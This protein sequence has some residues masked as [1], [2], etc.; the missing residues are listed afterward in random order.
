MAYKISLAGDLG[1]GKSTVASILTERLGAEYY[2]TGS[3]MRRLAAEQGMTIEEFNRSIEGKP[4]TDRLIDDGLAALS[5]DPRALIIDSRMAWHFVRGTF[6]V[7]LS[8]DPDI[9]AA[10]IFCARRSEER[11]DSV[12]QARLSIAARKASERS[13]YKAF[14]GVDNKDMMNYDLVLDTSYI[15]PEQVADFI[16]MAFDEW[17]N[18]P[19]FRACMMS[20]RR[21][22]Y[23][24][25]EADLETAAALSASYDE[26]EI[27]ETVCVQEHDGGFYVV[28]GVESA[29]GQALS[30]VLM[31]SCRL[32]PGAPADPSAFV[33]MANSL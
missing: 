29:L 23:P 17:K 31:I 32:L 4:E 14:Y 20:P 5:D 30:D 9:S 13:R 1:S 28:E 18:D 25:D 26:G 11:F 33:R 12:E 8:T 19:D 22:F 10:R 16:C 7:Y 15:T 21:L 3:I 24:D 6:R 2:S 27:P